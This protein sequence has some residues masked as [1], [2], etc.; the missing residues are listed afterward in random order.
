MRWILIAA[1]MLLAACATPFHA[2]CRDGVRYTVT[3]E[4]DEGMQVAA[5][6]TPI[7]CGINPSRGGER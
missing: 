2:V 7:E 3:A 5:D 1:T 6:G 4:G